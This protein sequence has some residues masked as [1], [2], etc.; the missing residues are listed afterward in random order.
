[1]SSNDDLRTRF[2]KDAKERFR[3]ILD[4]A[5]DLGTDAA[6]NS[7]VEIVRSQAHT[8]RGAA[9]MLDFDDVKEAAAN[10]EDVA[11]SALQSGGELAG[12]ALT[13]ALEQ[14]GSAIDGLV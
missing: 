8:I 6:L 3:T 2:T 7:S 14:L 9:G 11:A 12:D 4:V 13:V 5:A 1:M 10:L